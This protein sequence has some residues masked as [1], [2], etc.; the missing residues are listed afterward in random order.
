MN[1]RRIRVGGDWLAR[2]P[3]RVVGWLAGGRADK[4]GLGGWIARLG[5][6]AAKGQWQLKFSRLLPS[7]RAKAQQPKI[8]CGRSRYLLFI[9]WKAETKDNFPSPSKSRSKKKFNLCE[10]TSIDHPP[11]SLEPHQTTASSRSLS[12]QS[13]SVNFRSL[14]PTS[15]TQSPCLPRSKLLSRRPRPTPPRS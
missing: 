10:D 12:T 8:A 5:P 15:H 13:S 2:I 7:A 1:T 3:Y 14:F 11:Y 4:A 6:R 9:S